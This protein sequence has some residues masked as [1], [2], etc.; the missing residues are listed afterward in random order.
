MV[1]VKTVRP[2]QFWTKMV[3]LDR[4]WSP[5]FGAAGPNLATKNG[6]SQTKIVQHR[7]SIETSFNRLKWKEG[8]VYKP[9]YVTRIMHNLDNIT[10]NSAA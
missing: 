3:W 8:P 1:R 9:S 7:K 4:F 2:D 6:A 5:K 10:L